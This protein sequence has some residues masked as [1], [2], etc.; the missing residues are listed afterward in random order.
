MSEQVEF[1]QYVV[2]LARGVLAGLGELPD[3][4]TQQNAHNLI[5]A[6]HSFAVLKMLAEKT[7]GNL[8]EDEQNLI[9][10][11]ITDLQ[12]RMSKLQE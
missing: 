1:S 3:P 5:L 12:S 8:D 9:Q 7:E 10:S 11:I 2:S 4:E 6:K